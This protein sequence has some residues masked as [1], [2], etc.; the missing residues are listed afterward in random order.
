MNSSNDKKRKAILT[1][2]GI[3]IISL[4]VIGISY[5][6]WIF[7][8][9]QEGENVVNLACL[10]VTFTGRNDITLDEAYP[11]EDNELEYFLAN[12]VP[13][14]FII[15]NNC[16]ELTN[17]TVNLESLNVTQNTQLEDSY[18][19]TILYKEDY[20]KKL[21]KSPKLTGNTLN[22]ENKVISD[23]RHAYGLYSFT[24]KAQET[25]E[26]NLQ[27]YLDKDTPM[28][29]EIMNASWQGK[30]TISNSL[31]EDKFQYAGTL[32][33]IRFANEKNGM[34]NYQEQLTKIVIEDNLNVKTA[35]A[36]GNVYGPFD[37]SSL[38][39]N[40]VQSYVV[41]EANDTNCIG[42]LQGDGGVK[43][44]TDS[45][46]IFYG[47]E[48]VITI[49]G[50][51]N[52]DTSMAQKLDFLFSGMESLQ[53]IDL[54]KLDTSNVTSMSQLLYNCKSI[55]KL[56]LNGFDTSNVID[57]SGIFSGMSSLQSLDLRPLDTSNVTNMGTMFYKMTNLQSI[58][59]SSLDTSHVTDMRWMFQECEKLTEID[60][61][62][63]D[64]SSVIIMTNMFKAM[65]NLK[66]LD[67]SNFDTSSV[68]DFNFMF[69][70]LKSL[71]KLTFGPKFIHKSGA[72]T[73]GMYIGCLSQDRPSDSS[74]QGVSFD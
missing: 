30:I 51:E 19:D 73:N 48:N 72:S 61:S 36:G 5:A 46:S 16:N 67:L 24:L 64:T 8:R 47:F 2:L 56:N 52:L 32:R 55:T 34:W 9:H 66:E 1:V 10:N 44:G 60:L 35:P 4:V 42:Y 37:E 22:D 57:M 27:I 68:N 43:T 45:S 31:K 53:T 71:Q 50:L 38:K 25:Q 70:N 23:A 21:N 28:T 3:F 58:D 14:H 33:Y 17:V 65:S 6:W 41:C 62:N 54:S 74:W 11:L 39:N 12:Q 13:Y 59:L 18:I 26:F 7:T 20:H 69:L 15:T 29:D 49:D 40:S 63:F